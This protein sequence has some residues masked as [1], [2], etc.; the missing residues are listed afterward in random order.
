MEIYQLTSV[1]E[2]QLTFDLRHLFSLNE[3]NW[4]EKNDYIPKGVTSEWPLLGTHTNIWG[5]GA[6]IYELIVLTP[7]VFDMRKAA[8]EGGVLGKIK[9]HRIPEYSKALMDL[10]HQCLKIDPARRPTLQE[11]ETKVESRRTSFRARWA[12]GENVP[13][14][15]ALHLHSDEFDRMDFG[16]FIV[17]EHVPFDWENNTFKSE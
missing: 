3:T 8:T 14:E 13:E 15:A 6:C 1:Q 4:R 2:Q 12:R 7:V 5:V 11:L 16:P 10:V 17:G 9:T